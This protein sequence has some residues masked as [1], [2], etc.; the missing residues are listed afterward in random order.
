MRA[1]TAR[2]AARVTL[3]L[4]GEPCTS[5]GR[6]PL[7]SI[8]CASSVTA[9]SSAR[10]PRA[11]AQRAQAKACGVKARHSPL[12][13]TV[14]TTAARARASPYRRRA[15]QARR[16]SHPPRGRDE[17][18]QVGRFKTGAGRIVDQHPVLGRRLITERLKPANTDS[19]R[20]APPIAV[21]SLRE[22][23]AI[24]RHRAS[25]AATTT[26]TRSMRASLS[27]GRS[28]HSS[29]VVP[30]SGAYCLGRR[31]VPGPPRQSLLRS[32]RR[33]LQLEPRPNTFAL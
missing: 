10:H 23:G 26:T 8:A 5:T 3:I 15:L 17:A 30:A 31:D 27:S 25:S 22:P 16:R 21:S 4:N 24:S 12:R 33:D 14:S 28:E 13:S 32:V 29:T 19:W 1:A 9:T 18:L 7:R 6:A 20:L 2:S 11:R